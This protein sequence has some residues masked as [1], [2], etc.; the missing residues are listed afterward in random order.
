MFADIQRVT[1]GFGLYI[2][3]Q[4]G[5]VFTVD[6]TSHESVSFALVHIGGYIGFG[7]E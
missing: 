5:G 4:A 1:G 6:M 2:G 7:G 3:R